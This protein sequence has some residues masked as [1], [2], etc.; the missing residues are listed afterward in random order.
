MPFKR[1]AG[2]V[3]NI[4]PDRMNLFLRYMSGVGNEGLKLDDSTLRSIR[5]ATEQPDRLVEYVDPKEA[6]RDMFL[7]A[8]GLERRFAE[9]VAR[10]QTDERKQENK[11]LGLPEVTPL[12]QAAAESLRKSQAI[13]SGDFD[14]VFPEGLRQ[15]PIEITRF[16]LGP[17]VPTS[18]PVD[19]YMFEGDKAVT[20]TLGRF[21][22]DVKDDGSIRVTDTYDM[23]NEAED[24]DLVSGSFRPD[25]ALLKLKGLYDP[26]ARARLINQINIEQGNEPPMGRP[27]MDNRG[28]QEKIKEG[29]SSPTGS[30]L[31]QVA[32]AAMYLAPFKPQPFDIDIT[33]PP[34]SR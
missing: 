27:P 34:T 22:A 20:Q 19:P 23:V 28:Y 5:Q 1:A 7:L 11:A 32:R 10:S 29:G 31:S 21:M 9:I 13:R 14:S 6:A 15:E 30:P 3:F 4:L 8:P 18:G 17:G 26:E 25:K 12:D 33:I 2:E 24:P 16:A